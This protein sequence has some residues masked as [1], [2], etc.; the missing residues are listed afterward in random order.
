MRDSYKCKQSRQF[1][2]DLV[3]LSLDHNN[4]GSNNQATKF[5]ENVNTKSLNK[6]NLSVPRMAAMRM[7]KPL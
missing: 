5:K 6:K 2:N 3:V 1:C 7:P 4:N